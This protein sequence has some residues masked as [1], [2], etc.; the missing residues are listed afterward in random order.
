[1]MEIRRV[2]TRDETDYAFVEQLMNVSFPPEEQRD[3]PQ[4]RAYSDSHPLFRNHIIL[5]DHVPVGMISFWDMGDFHYIEHFA[6]DPPARNKG[7]GKQ[8]L[9]LI[10][11]QWDHPIVLEVEM[12]TNETS[13]RRI[14]FYRQTG[15][16]LHE[17]PYMQ[18]PYRKGDAEMPMRLM[19]CGAI[20]MAQDFDRIKRKIHKEV[21]GVEETRTENP[22]A[23]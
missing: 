15:F 3:T 11:K 14:R 18:P 5:A 2:T 12:P 23:K 1:M 10:R 4:Q 7:Y 22:S 21:Y 16:T 19:T 13:I 20:S 9:E 17:I 8:A 6:I